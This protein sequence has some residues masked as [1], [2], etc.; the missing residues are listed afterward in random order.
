M[1]HGETEYNARFI[2]QGSGVDAPLTQK[3]KDDAKNIAS[4]FKKLEIK[5]IACSSLLRARQT[6]AI[7]N[8]GIQVPIDFYE[9]LKELHFGEWEKDPIDLNWV[10]FKKNFY[11][12]NMSPPEGETKM[13]FFNRLDGEI[14]KIVNDIEDD[15][16]LIVCH[17]MVIRILISEWFQQTTYE[18]IHAIDLPNLALYR[19]EI[20]Y[21]KDRII[22]LNYKHIKF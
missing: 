19:V 3:G 5:H 17:K 13:D 10:K 12:R 20:E 22:P 7:I 14:K 21:D 2:L 9:D 16:I 18:E 6:A 15:P 8:D 1:R 4:N 11:H